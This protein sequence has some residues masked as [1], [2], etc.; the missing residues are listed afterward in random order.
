MKFNFYLL[1][2]KDVF[3]IR[4]ILKGLLQGFMAFIKVLQ[5]VTVLEGVTLGFIRFFKGFWVMIF[6]MV[7]VLYQFWENLW[8]GRFVVVWLIF[9][10][11]VWLI[12]QWFTF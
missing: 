10:L 9:L 2:V 5:G 8:F 4:L 1:E 11:S 12:V 6:V 3:F 7:L